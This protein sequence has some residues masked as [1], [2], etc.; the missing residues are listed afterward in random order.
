MP[1]FSLQHEMEFKIF[2]K[3]LIEYF[4]IANFNLKKLFKKI[5]IKINYL[6]KLSFSH[7]SL[8]FSSK[9]KNS[10]FEYKINIAGLFLYFL[11][12]NKPRKPSNSLCSKRKIIESVKESYKEEGDG[13][14][15]ENQFNRVENW[16]KKRDRY[17][18]YLY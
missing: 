13:S 7:L 2:K 3:E 12:L 18:K 8:A 16:N 11:K 17:K 1:I 4:H 6:L 15:Y 9:T 10:K 14:A 5:L